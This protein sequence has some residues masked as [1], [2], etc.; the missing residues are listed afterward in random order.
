MLVYLNN[1]IM[2][3]N[4]KLLAAM[5]FA[6]L[7]ITSCEKDYTSQDLNDDKTYSVNAD[8]IAKEV[9]LLM[10][11][12][13]SQK[14]VLD[15]LSE[16]KYGGSL[17]SIVSHLENSGVEQSQLK[18]LNKIVELSQDAVN[19]AEET[20]IVE[21]PELWL[22]KPKT[23]LKSSEV[24]IS[25]APEG[26]ENEWETIEAFDLN[27]KMVLLNANEE[28]EVPVIVVEL[29]GMESMK[30]K[31]QLMNKELRALGAQSGISGKLMQL[32]S[33]QGLETTKINKISLTKDQEPWI[34]GAAEIYAITSGLRGSSNNKIAE[35]NIVAMPY[36][37]DDNKDYYPNQ[38]ILFWDD[39]AYKAAN[40]QLYEQDSNYNYKDLV[41]IITQGVFDITGIL[42]AEPWVSALGKVA[43]AIIEVMP[44][45]WYTDDDDYVDSFYTIEKDKTYTNYFGAAGNAKMSMSPFTIEDN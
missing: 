18:S 40:I 25:F 35:I 11:N 28:P 23:E 45:E 39:Y 21:I 34:K 5:V 16:N 38:V 29:H 44:D 27:G 7:F 4:L 12:E 20:G 26:D 3:Q 32:K 42:T 8:V 17:E 41:K 13:T 43:V 19:K 30:M 37:D 2:K 6:V 10:Q 33:T 36:L 1:S 24:L 31:V 22:F 15:F 9:T 14:I